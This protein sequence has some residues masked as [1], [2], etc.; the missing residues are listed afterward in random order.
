[1][2]QTELSIG[3]DSERMLAL[4][5]YSFNGDRTTIFNGIN[6]S[7]GKHSYILNTDLL[8][9]G[10]YLLT[11]SGGGVSVNSKLVVLR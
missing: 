8:S 7:S 10:I 9:S 11:I 1:M 2:N 3:T 4:D 5:L 6:F